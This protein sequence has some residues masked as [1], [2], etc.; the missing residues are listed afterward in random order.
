[1]REGMPSI[2]DFDNGNGIYDVVTRKDYEK[3]QEEKQKEA[4][5]KNRDKATEEDNKKP[6]SAV[7]F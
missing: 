3:W 6:Y 2:F 7:P 4:D 5:N 1:M